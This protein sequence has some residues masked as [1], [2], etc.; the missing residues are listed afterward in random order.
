MKNRIYFQTQDPTEPTQ[1]T[2]PTNPIDDPIPND[3]NPDPYPVTDPIPGQPPPVPTPPEPIP[4][5]PPDVTFQLSAS[6]KV[7]NSDKRDRRNGEP[8]YHALK[9]RPVAEFFNRLM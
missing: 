6:K 1:P 5:F 4:E 8:Q 2:G 9:Q 3:P 7:E